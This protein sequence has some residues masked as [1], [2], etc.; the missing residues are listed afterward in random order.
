MGVGP[1]A[2]TKT[3]RAQGGE[4]GPNVVNCTGRRSCSTPPGTKKAEE[5]SPDNL[6]PQAMLAKGRDPSEALGPGPVG[7][8]LRGL[9]VEALPQLLLHRDLEDVGVL[10]LDA[11]QLLLEGI[12]PR[13]GAVVLEVVLYV[14][15]GF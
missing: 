5:T 8:V 2:S 4:R 1:G 15:A 14:L 9:P 13:C 11:L 6:G 12:T 7:P 3:G 10:L